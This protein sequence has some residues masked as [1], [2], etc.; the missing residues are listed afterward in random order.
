M[1]AAVQ[2]DGDDLVIDGQ[3]FDLRNVRRIAVVGAGK[4]GAG[5][6]AEL[7][8]ILGGRLMAEKQ[9]IGWVNVP[10]DCVRE[11]TRIHL[12]G[13]R[14][15]GRNEPTEAGVRGTD[16]MLKIAAAFGPGDLCLCLLSGGGSALMPAPVEGVTLEDKVALTRH[17]SSAGANIAELNTVRKQLSRVKGGGLARRCGAGQI[18]SLIISDVLGD[19]LDVIASGPTVLDSSTPAEALAILERFCAREEGI[20]GRVFEYLERSRHTG[21]QRSA[22]AWHVQNVIIGNNAMAVDAAGLAAERLGYSQA[23]CS[24]TQLEGPIEEIGIHLRRS[25]YKCATTPAQIV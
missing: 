11:L 10:N 4:A 23:M 15:A 18:V 7:E 13:A 9:L 17:L 5:M 20:S 3:R 12:H 8:A 21:P 16:E 1:R 2:L 19:P 22:S 25:Q 6:A 24:A 14:P